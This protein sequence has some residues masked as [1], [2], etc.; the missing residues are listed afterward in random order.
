MSHPERTRTLQSLCW[1]GI[2][3]GEGQTRPIPDRVIGATCNV[4]PLERNRA[5]LWWKAICPG[6]G[7]TRPIP[8]R[9]VG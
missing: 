4:S 6:E 8:D 3:L 5:E 9:V 1:E 7:Q 2:C